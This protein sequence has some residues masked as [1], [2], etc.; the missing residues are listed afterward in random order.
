MKKNE[1]RSILEQEDK[2]MER[3]LQFR[4]MRRAE[5]D[6]KQRDEHTVTR[7]GRKV[8]ET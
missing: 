1:I 2:S 7:V 6:E 4:K 5:T 3:I 8:M